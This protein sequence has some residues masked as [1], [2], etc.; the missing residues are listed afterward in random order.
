MTG[1]REVHESCSGQG[2]SKESRKHDEEFN[3]FLTVL[4][5][6]VI[7]IYNQINAKFF[8]YSIII[9]YHD[10]LHV[11]SITCS[12]SGG[13]CI[14]PVSGI[15]TLCMLPYVAPIKSGRSPLLIGATYGSIQSV[16][17]PYL[18]TYS[19]EQSPS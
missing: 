2:K 10:R 8:I 17:I 18:L 7:E 4:H 13:H 1:E 5:S 9:L 15:F 12:S 16:G 11:S 14:F 6:A 3:G 19:M